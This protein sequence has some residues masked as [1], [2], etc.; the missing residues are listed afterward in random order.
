MTSIARRIQRL[1]ERFLPEPETEFSRRLRARMEAGRR[2]LQEARGQSV[3]DEVPLPEMNAPMENRPRT[4]IHL[5]NSGR[6]RA[7]RKKECVLLP[8]ASR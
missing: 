2:R 3:T 8:G 1:E 6:E 7:A 5:L 4:M